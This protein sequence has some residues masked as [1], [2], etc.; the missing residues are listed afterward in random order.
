MKN[1]LMD[2]VGLVSKQD[3]ESRGFESTAG[4]KLV[5]RKGT[6]KSEEELILGDWVAVMGSFIFF[7]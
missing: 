5:L 2:P 7:P 4:V 1:V 6:G 3:K